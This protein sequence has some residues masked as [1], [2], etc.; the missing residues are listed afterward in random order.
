[1]VKNAYDNGILYNVNTFF[2]RLLPDPAHFPT[3]TLILYTS[4]H[5]QTLFENGA[6]WLHCNNTRAEAS[7]PLLVLGQL[8]TEPDTT[9]PASHSSIL[10][11]LLDWIGV[12]ETARL[13]PYAPSLLT[14]TPASPAHRFFIS[15][16]GS[17]VAFDEQR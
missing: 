5:G 11:T 13:H 10:P 9:Y 4:D 8:K 16:N 12:P 3:N 14:A 2:T 17:V 1:L 6:D 15:G 7:V